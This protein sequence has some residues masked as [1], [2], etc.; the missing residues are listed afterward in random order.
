MAI[1]A[2]AHIVR[3]MSQPDSKNSHN[4]AHNPEVS[5]LSIDTAFPNRDA[6]RNNSNQQVD[7]QDAARVNCIDE[8]QQEQKL[9][10]ETR[11]PANHDSDSSRELLPMA[12]ND[13]R[14]A[15]SGSPRPA[16]EEVAFRFH[17]VDQRHPVSAVGNTPALETLEIE[18]GTVSMS[19]D[20]DSASLWHC[21]SPWTTKCSFAI[22]NASSP[23]ER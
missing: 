5:A 17:E 23:E 10:P 1:W 2:V 15:S 7:R 22:A 11:T 13:H 4:T 18:L 8:P 3:N 16:P 19:R 14:A 12:T 20:S 6:T 9:M 21:K